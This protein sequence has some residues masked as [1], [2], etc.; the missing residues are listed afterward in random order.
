MYT[1]YQIQ[2]EQTN[3]ER[4]RGTNLFIVIKSTD[5]VE[6]GERKVKITI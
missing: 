1:K 3:I 5:G 6:R 2:P 4:K